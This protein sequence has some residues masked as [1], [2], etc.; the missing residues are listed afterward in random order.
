LSRPSAAEAPDAAPALPWRAEALE[1]AL[2]PLWPGLRVMA[3]ARTDSTN[4][5]LVEA[6]RAAPQAFAP[7]L[8]VAEAQ[9]AGRG[10]LGRAWHSAPG[11]SLTFSVAVPMARATLEGLSLAV[12]VAVAEGLEPNPGAAPRVRLKWPNDLWLRAPGSDASGRKLA[13]ILIE[14]VPAGEPG[15]RVVVVGVGLNVQPLPPDAAVPETPA[16]WAE[17]EPQADAA[18]LLHRIA[19]ALAAA[20][21]RFDQEGL[22]EPTR[23]AFADRDLLAGR[24]IVTTLASLPHGV[25]EGIDLDGAL[26]VR[27]PDGRRVRVASGEVSVRPLTGGAVSRDAAGAA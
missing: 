22:A 15:A 12:G 16:A 5:R 21:V 6:A 8:L 2:R 25:A 11:A 17:V 14:A 13:G 10:R 9:T 20:L 18:A 23:R 4:T 19:P 1:A 26:L 27:A 7:T 24:P 3:L